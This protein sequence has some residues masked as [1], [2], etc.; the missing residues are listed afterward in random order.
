M[1]LKHETIIQL[2]GVWNVNLWQFSQIFVTVSMLRN[3]K[4]S[5]FIHNQGEIE[6]K[7]MP[8]HYRNNPRLACIISAYARARKFETII[9]KV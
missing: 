6:E 5:T 7:N 1:L 2:N 3:T 4:P 8:D 9:D